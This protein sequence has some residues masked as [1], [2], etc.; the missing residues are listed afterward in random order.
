MAL[1]LTHLGEAVPHYLRDC[2]EQARLWNPSFPI[3]LILDPIH[4]SNP[5]FTNLD[6]ILVFTDELTMTPYHRDFLNN[7]N[8]DINFRKGY[9]RFV[10]ERFYFVE[11]LMKKY[12]IKKAFSMEYDV[13]IYYDLNTLLQKLNALPPSFRFVKDNQ[14]KGHP[15]FVYIPS[16]EHISHFNCYMTLTVKLP[17]TDM[18]IMAEYSNHYKSFVSYFPVIPTD[19]NNKVKVRKSLDDNISCDNCFFLSTDFDELNILFDSLVVGQFVGGIDSRNTNG[20]KITKYLNESA[21]YSMLELNLQWTKNDEKWTPLLNGYPLVFIHCHSKALN[22]FRSDKKDFPN[23]DY[24]VKDI[25]SKLQP[26]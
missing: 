8:G 7:Y 17:L 20:V 5:F 16:I 1:I 22:N 2:V 19:V 12:S 11:E 24:D 25:F 18:E 21:L 13:L 26:N 15:A 9:W 14:I 6:L 3:Y 23:D 4:R 10:K